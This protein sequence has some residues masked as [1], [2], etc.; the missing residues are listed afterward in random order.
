M[1]LAHEFF[2]GRRGPLAT[3]HKNHSEFRFVQIIT[4]V[5]SAGGPS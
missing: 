4:Q 5:H 1:K 3:L 2:P